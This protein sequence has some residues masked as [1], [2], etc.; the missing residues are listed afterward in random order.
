M[1]H[2]RTLLLGAVEALTF[3]TLVG[4]AHAARP[5]DKDRDFISLHFDHAADRDDGHSAAADRTVLETLYGRQWIAQH[6]AAVSGAYGLNKPTFNTK[7]DRVMEIAFEGCCGWISAHRDWKG[8]VDTLVSR[9]K[10]TLLKGG[11]VWIKEGGQSDITMEVVQRLKKEI[12]GLDARMRIHLVQ[13]GKWN[14]DQTTPVALAY[15]KAE[16]DYIRIRD[17][18][19]LLNKRGGDPEFVKLATT[20]PVFGPAWKAAFEY[21]PSE[22]RVDFSDTGELFHILGLGEVDIA[23]FQKRYLT[24]RG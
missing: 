16:V 12:P 4:P 18:N 20:H 8:A 10:A 6:C 14:E 22:I 11:D 1:L 13:H 2:R 9:W 17:A 7:S 24:P 3:C 19:R 5:F 23:E 15:V 21:Y